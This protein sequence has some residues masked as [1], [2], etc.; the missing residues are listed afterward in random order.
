MIQF[1]NRGFI[2]PYDVVES[3]LSELEQVFTFNDHRKNLFQEY[4][5]FLNSIQNLDILRFKLEV[6]LFC[7]KNRSAQVPIFASLKVER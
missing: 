7:E 4:K 6:Q 3:D 1:D 5:L 2:T